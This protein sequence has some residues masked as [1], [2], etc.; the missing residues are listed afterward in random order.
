MTLEEKRTKAILAMKE[1]N[2]A[3]KG[4]LRKLRDLP[5]VC[6]E[7]LDVWKQAEEFIKD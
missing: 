3:L 1:E 7:R 6:N 5:P 4:I 2:E